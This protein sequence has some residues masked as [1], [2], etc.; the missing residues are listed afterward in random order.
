MIFGAVLVWKRNMLVLRRSIWNNV[1]SNFFEP[2]VYLL[3][4]GY[5]V[6]HFIGRLD[7]IP[8]KGFVATG[9]IATTVMFSASFECT[10]STFVRMTFQKTFD[11]MIAT[12][13]GIESVIIGEMFFAATKAALMS[14]MIELSIYLFRFLTGWHWSALLVPVGAF[15]VA[16]AFAVVAMIVTSFVSYIETFNYYI[17]LVVTP[18]FMFSGAFFPLTTLPAPLRL[19]AWLTP[20]WHGVRMERGLFLGQWRL[21]WG[22]S[23]WL[24]LFT[25]MTFTIPVI[26]MRRKLIR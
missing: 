13:I 14:I 1:V 12:P 8:Y 4:M 5:G 23:I 10:I 24:V 2:L 20:I 11:A 16:L 15:L 22:S 6:G 9:I 17:S 19:V 3:G 7:G 26:L 21:V 18:L 25:A